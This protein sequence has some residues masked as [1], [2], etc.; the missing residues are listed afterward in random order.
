M[1]RVAPD[2]WQ[3]REPAPELR[4]RYF[5]E[6]HWD[7]STLPSIARDGVRACADAT[8]RIRSTSRPYD[9]TVG[10]VAASGRLLAGALHARGV[11]AGDVVAFQLPN[12][13]EAI[14]CVYGLLFLGVVGVP[15]VHI[16]GSREVEHILKQSR[17]KALITADAF[18]H[19]DFLANLDSMQ[20]RLPDLEHVIVVGDREP[21]PGWNAKGTMW[22][23]LLAGASPLESLPQVDPDSPAMIGYTSGTTAVAKGVVHTHRTLLSEMRS[24]DRFRADDPTRP[25]TPDVVLS[26]APVAHITGLL[27]VLLPLLTGAPMHLVDRW[28]PAVVLDA[29]V[30]DGLS[31]GAGATFFLTSLLDHP[32]FDPARHLPLMRRIGMGGSPIPAEV[33]RRAASLGILLTRAY[34]STEHP[35]TTM[36]LHCDP[37]DKRL[38]TDGRPMPGVELRLVDD[39]GNDVA[40]GDPGEIISRGPDLFVGY[41]DPALTADTIDADGWYHTGDVGVLDGDG[42]LTITDRKKDIII[43]GGENVSASEVEELLQRLGGVSEVAVVAAPDPTYGEH[44]CAFVR[45]APDATP[46]DLAEVQHHL[47][48]SGLARQKWPEELRFLDDFPRT[49]SGK[50]QKHVL[51]ARLRAEQA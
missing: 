34:G 23:Q 46:F 15:V 41:T 32:D 18:G 45:L 31:S 16:Y 47:E 28:D 4:R 1:G 44:G 6:G 39:D 2:E 25:E 12:W 37:E 29:M 19:M 36:S 7:D 14:A 13:S 49:A 48:R 5:A 35:S 9:G 30:T 10:D 20:H 22:E 11:T 21:D 50:I 38:Y 8:V 33:A 40:L 42:Y 24:Y 17:A 43:R 27:Q 51:R 26:G 3:L